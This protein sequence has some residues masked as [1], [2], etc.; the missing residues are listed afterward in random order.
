MEAKLSGRQLACLTMVYII[1]SSAALGSGDMAGRGAWLSMVMA[2]LVMVP[3]VVLYA[4]VSVLYGEGDLFDALF[5]ALGPVLGWGAALLALLYCLKLGAAA[6][7]DFP[8]FLHTVTLV[9]T[10]KALLVLPLGLLCA[11]LAR[12]G[13][14]AMGKAAILFSAVVGILAAATFFLLLPNMELGRLLPVLEEGWRPVVLNAAGLVSVPFGEMVLL[15]CLFCRQKEGQS[16]QT[17]WLWGLMLGGAYL[18]VSLL[19]NLLALGAENLVALRY[20]SYSAAGIINLADFFQ[21]VEVVVACYLLM[22][23]ILK[24]GVAL[25][26]ASLGLAKLLR[27]KDSRRGIW[28]LGIVMTAAALLVP[29]SFL[30]GTHSS[31]S[32]FWLTLPFALGLPLLLWGLGELRKRRG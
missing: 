31:P 12:L 24:A 7:R 32:Y 9:K 28:P 11:Y 22:C 23:D 20:P 14:G 25:Y 8:E 5:Q 18:V 2:V 21:R 27:L 30:Q 26:A 13:P 3:V 16:R 15:L 10:P 1:G 6:L 19:R 17:A 29:Q 4:R